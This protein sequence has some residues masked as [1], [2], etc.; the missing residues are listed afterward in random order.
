M[1]GAVSIADFLS[2]PHGFKIPVYQR[3]YDWKISNCKRLLDDME[4][5]EAE[6]RKS[7]FFGG[8][9]YYFDE[10]KIDGRKKNIIIDGQQRLTTVS[11]LLLALSRLMKKDQ[12]Q[13]SVQ[14][15]QQ[16]YDSYLFFEK[17]YKPRLIQVADDL[18]NY[19]QLLLE[20]NWKNENS[21]IYNNYK[22]IY[23]RI[24]N[25]ITSRKITLDQLFDAFKRLEIIKMKLDGDDSAQRIFE[26]INSTGLSLTEGDK[27]RNYI[28]M[29]QSVYHQES[30]YESYWKPLEM[31]TNANPK[32]HDV[33]MFVRDYLSI[34]DKR[35]PAKNEIY[36]AFISYAEIHGYGSDE[37]KLKLLQ[38]L[39]RYARLY[40]ILV[41]GSSSAIGGLSD[42]IDHD[43]SFTIKRLNWLKTKV[44]RPFFL[45]VLEYYLN[46]FLNLEEVKQVFTIVESYCF[47]RIICDRPTNSLDMV[48][49]NLHNQ[50]TDYEGDSTH[51]NYVE[52]LKYILTSKQDR[53]LY[54]KDD[55]FQ[56]ALDEKKVY[57]MG[58][59]YR[60][61][62][63]E[64]YENMGLAEGI[65][66]I[67]AGLASGDYT[68]EHIMPQNLNAD[69]KAA[70]DPNAEEIH[71][72]WIH[73]L[74]NLT[75]TMFNS[76]LSDNPFLKKKILKDKDGKLIGYNASGLDINKWVRVQDKWTES[77]IQQRHK[78]M[79]EEAVKLWPYYDTDLKPVEKP[80]N[81]LSLAE[82]YNLKGWSIKGFSLD[83]ERQFVSEWSE[84]FRRIMSKLY[85]E[86]KDILDMMAYSNDNYLAGIVSSKEQP[87]GYVK[88]ADGIYIKLGDGTDTKINNLRRFFA[89]YEK[90]P[91]DLVFY[92]SQKAYTAEDG[93]KIRASY[94][95]TA[96]PIIQAS[97]ADSTEGKDCFSEK[98]KYTNNFIATNTGV[99]G[100]SL[101]CLAKYDSVEVTLYISKSD[102]EKNKKIF[103]T[104]YS[105]KYEIEGKL[106][107]E[108]DWKR[109][110]NFKASQVSLNWK[111]DDKEISIYRQKD[112][113]NL[114]ANFQA[115]W[116][117]K[118]YDVFMPYLKEMN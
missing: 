34:K 32:N 106:D 115:A 10:D 91:R 105:H 44:A 103:D 5:I 4:D 101:R 57:K 49:L 62:I 16:I 93:K 111:G 3:N 36:K 74:G 39:K 82:A 70:L 112:N 90:D 72:K 21:N 9:I 45:R 35:I 78:N 54:P 24:Q 20:E 56:K 92:L 67:Y 86:N 52:K 30:Y 14:K 81:A 48:F 28:L 8:V 114:A 23:D 51:K 2:D 64:R 97:F 22:Y 116:A 11:L 89:A 25:D 63:L 60:S 113:W 47:R 17:T 104:L 37:G 83:G 87:K 69:W 33:S 38:D 117:R 18:D 102:K 27:I 73:R 110:D 71:E 84:A 1:E 118:F 53:T 80:V 42:K 13:D 46:G 66:D 61:Y 29:N 19:R 65:K 15:S 79:V 88:I 98:Q 77:E 50:I 95:A 76:S 31:L 94:W 107:R 58:P 6:G 43:L 7:H 99:S 96:L 75:L 109:Y 40:E 100:I 85:L 26:S 55:E 59:N 108:L 68:I 12:G 41:K